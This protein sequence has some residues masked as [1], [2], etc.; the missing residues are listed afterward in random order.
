MYFLI[1]SIG[2]APEGRVKV[3]EHA[4]PPFPLVRYVEAML[5]FCKILTESNNKQCVFQ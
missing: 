2:F 4:T 1:L 3:N 5:F